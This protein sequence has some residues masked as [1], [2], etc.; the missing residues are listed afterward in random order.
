M[1]TKTRRDCSKKAAF[2]AYLTAARKRGKLVED[3]VEIAWLSAR[4]GAELAAMSQPTFSK[5]TADLIEDGYIRR[6]KAEKSEQADSYVLLIPDS[7][8]GGVLR[9]HYGERETEGERKN[10]QSK[11]ER[12]A[13]HGDNVVPPLPELRW[14]SSGRKPRRGLI[15]GTRMVRQGTSLTDKIPSKR[16]PGKKRREILAYLL[17]NGGSA[18]RKELLENFAGQKTIWKDFKKQTLADLLGRRR[19]YK[20]QDL[21][22]GPPVIEL[23]DGGIA[24]VEGWQEALEHHRELGGEEE[25][26]IRQKVDH[27]R[28]RAGFRKRNKKKA[29]R[30]PTEEEMAEGREERQKRR[31]AARLVR[32]G[33]AAHIVA[34]DVLGASGFIEDLRPVED[35]DPPPEEPELEVHPLA[36]DCLECSCRAP[37]YART[38]SGV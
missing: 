10:E 32:E 20:G 38:W 31:K 1:P 4:T 37:R 22:V 34:E 29:D 15:E 18:T 28:Q 33:M 35:P 24:L 14:S 2:R 26:A 8:E 12:E 17:E 5:C 21:S 30:A 16:R 25:A 36:C 11:G 3:G 9:Y 27:L 23:T 19:Q 13:P 6:I 7:S